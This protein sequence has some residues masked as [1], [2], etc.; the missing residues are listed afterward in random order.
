MIAED[1]GVYD[2]PIYGRRFDT[3]HNYTN[4]QMLS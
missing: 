1:T 2:K 4:T 3:S